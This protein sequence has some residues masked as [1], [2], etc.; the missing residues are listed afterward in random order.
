[1]LVQVKNPKKSE[2]T[3]F[4]KVNIDENQK[5]IENLIKEIGV[6][7]LDKTLEEL[8]KHLLGKRGPH[9]TTESLE[10]EVKKEEEK[11]EFID[12]NSKIF[13]E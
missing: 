1:M 6:E 8:N 12:T 10:E 3:E 5:I 7:V 13:S 2:L 4:T 9:K 11:E